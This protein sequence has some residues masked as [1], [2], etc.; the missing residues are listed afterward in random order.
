MFAPVRSA[1]EARMPDE[2]NDYDSFANY[3]QNLLYAIIGAVVIDSDWNSKAIFHICH[4]LY[5]VLL[6]TDNYGLL[7]EKLCE[8]H[9]ISLTYKEPLQI[10]YNDVMD[11]QWKCSALVNDKEIEVVSNSPITAKMK[12]ACNIYHHLYPIVLEEL[13]Y[14]PDKEHAIS[15]LEKLEDACLIDGVEFEY[16]QIT[17]DGLKKYH[18]RCTIENPIMEE[19]TFAES[20]A[21]AK[22]EAAYNIL[23][24]LFN[25]PDKL[26]FTDEID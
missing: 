8:G 11:Q 16:N 3:C 13:C 15:Q 9:N 14:L 23:W 19:N 4:T 10:K 1:T 22:K 21:L 20:K 6:Q 26:H 12:L 17:E 2:M 25:S 5:N 7:L 24:K 18:C